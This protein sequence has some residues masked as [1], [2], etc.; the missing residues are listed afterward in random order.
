MADRCRLPPPWTVDE[1]H[2]CFTVR[3]ADGQTCFAAAR[4]VSGPCGRVMTG[5]RRTPAGG[6][7][8]D[9]N[10][11]FTNCGYRFLRRVSRPG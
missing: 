2:P 11:A 6:S 4:Q 9:F 3:D 8:R 5:F 10:S 7:S 1:T